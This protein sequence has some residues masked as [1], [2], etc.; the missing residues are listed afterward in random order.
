MVCPDDMVQMHQKN[1]DGKPVGGGIA[2][3]EQ[4]TTWE[5][6]ECPNC[7]R[8]VVEYY[9]AIPVETVEQGIRAARS[10]DTVI[11]QSV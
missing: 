9:T 1:I 5:L 11:E 2:N 10:L 7:G 6:K 8:L 4:Y 3:D